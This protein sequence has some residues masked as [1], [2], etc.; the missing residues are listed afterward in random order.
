LAQGKEKK[1]QE[2]EV[3]IAKSSFPT[4]KAIALDLFGLYEKNIL[5]LVLAGSRVGAALIR[6]QREIMARKHKLSIKEIDKISTYVFFSIHFVVSKEIGRVIDRVKEQD[7]QTVKRLQQKL[8]FVEGLL[9]KY[10]EVRQGYLAYTFSNLNY[11]EEVKWEANMKSF[12]S[13]S[14]VLEREDQPLVY[15]SANLW[16]LLG[17]NLGLG[18]AGE[19]QRI[20]FNFEIGLK[21]VDA[22]IQSLRDLR[23]A[24][25]NLQKRKLV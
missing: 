10:P 19:K 12:R 25:V 18:A 9:E 8:D 22:L 2:I 23:E 24:I 14:S 4:F 7:R 11:F 15:P 16:F 17:S 20:S 3:E 13:P 6:S 5:R 1:P 21:D